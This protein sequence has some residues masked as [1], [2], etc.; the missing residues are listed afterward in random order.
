MI[1]F[2]Q[3]E[4]IA[5]DHC[6]DGAGVVLCRNKSGLSLRNLGDFPV[7]FLV[8]LKSQHGSRDD[9]DI[10][11]SFRLESSLYEIQAFARNGNDFAVRHLNFNFRRRDF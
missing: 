10:G 1:K 4:V 6:F 5:A 11:L 9:L 3:G 7:A 8:A 2:I